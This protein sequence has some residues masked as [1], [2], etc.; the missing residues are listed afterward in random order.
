[1]LAINVP[2]IF[3]PPPRDKVDE[4]VAA[5]QALDPNNVFVLSTDKK[6]WREHVP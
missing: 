5:F 2:T 4:E 6:L 3:I 1:M